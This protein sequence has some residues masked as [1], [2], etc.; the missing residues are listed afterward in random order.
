MRCIRTERFKL[1]RRYDDRERPV[2]PN[3][4]DGLS[5]DVLLDHGWADSRQDQEMLYDL[6]F[7]PTESDNLADR[8][9]A[10]DVKKHL[11][12]RLENWMTETG[13][14]IL[15]SGRLDPPKGSLL[16]DPDGLSPNQPPKRS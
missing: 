13:D 14:P 12:R 9:E 6:V 7:D 1:I 8:S 11:S 15:E 5:K 4:D 2:L 10:A 16:N 3:I